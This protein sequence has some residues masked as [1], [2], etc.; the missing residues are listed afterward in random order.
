MLNWELI[1]NTTPNADTETTYTAMEPD[2][3]MYQYRTEN[4]TAWDRYA[5]IE[6]DNLE[7]TSWETDGQSL[8]TQ[9]VRR[10]GIKHF[11]QVG[12]IGFWTLLNEER[13]KILVPVHHEAIRYEQPDF[14]VEET[15]DTLI[16]YMH[17]PE[18]LPDSVTDEVIDA[19]GSDKIQYQCYRIIL[20]LDKFALEYV[21]YE[22]VLEIPKPTTT[23][24]YDA[25]C[26]G[27]IHEGEAV[28]EESE[29]FSIYIEG[30]Q[31][32]WPGPTANSDVCITDIEI[33]SDGRI[34]ATRSDGYQVT[35]QD[36]IPKVDTY[37]TAATFLPDGKLLLTLSNGTT[38]TTSN[39][40]PGGTDLPYAEE[41]R[42]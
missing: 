30:T 40:V 19:V 32:E 39:T 15:G 17:S 8:T 22:Q 36:T 21:T 2:N 10:I 29:H 5:L 16:F 14:A 34:R 9:K 38:V 41:V 4:H 1:I 23:G 25:Y 18:D 7:G 24:T 33:T 27:Y 6:Y 3:R 37:L 42:F 26:I 28:S 11:P 35:S 31:Q 12:A 13:S 20:R